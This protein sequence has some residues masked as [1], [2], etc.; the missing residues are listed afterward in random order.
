VTLRDSAAP[1]LLTLIVV[2]ARYAVAADKTLRPVLVRWN[3]LSS[4]PRLGPN[5][6]FDAD[7][8][9][10]TGFLATCQPTALL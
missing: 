4:G 8:A 5:L 7:E 1:A 2:L 3:E 6:H 9:G 10:A